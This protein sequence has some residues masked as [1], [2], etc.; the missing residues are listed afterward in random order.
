MSRWA[1]SDCQ[2]QLKFLAASALSLEPRAIST[3]FL[4]SPR[5]PTRETSLRALARKSGPQLTRLDLDEVIRQVLALSH[6][7]L[8][9]H[10]IVAR[11]ELAADERPVMGDPVQL[12]QVLLNLI[13]NGIEAMKEV[14]ERARELTISS[15]PIR[16]ACSLRSRTLAWGWILR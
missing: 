13:M 2:A 15:V 10:D 11:A 16:A 8:Q 3:A 7:E 5:H 1:C 9:R 6:G 14:M 12:Q 4:Q